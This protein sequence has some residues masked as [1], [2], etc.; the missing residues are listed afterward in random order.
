MARLAVDARALAE[1]PHADEFGLEAP[2][3]EGDGPPG[4][5]APWLAML[6]PEAGY[7]AS[8][9]A[10][11]PEA[12]APP[13]LKVFRTATP[14]GGPTPDGEADAGALLLACT[15]PEAGRGTGRAET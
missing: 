8:L 7:V 13:A 11:L 3:G 12:A 15:A 4:G 14:D 1:L 5:G 10:L 2:E 9:C 6:E